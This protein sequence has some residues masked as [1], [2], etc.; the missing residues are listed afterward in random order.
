MALGE[1]V[2]VSRFPLPRLVCVHP[3]HVLTMVWRGVVGVTLLKNKIIGAREW[4]IMMSN[5]IQPKV[6]YVPRVVVRM[7]S[8][9]FR[10]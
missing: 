8:R 6:R 3:E 1:Y 9:T 10:R 7:F 4:S 5:K 2:G